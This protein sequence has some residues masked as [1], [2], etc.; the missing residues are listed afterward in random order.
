[1]RQRLERSLVFRRPFDLSGEIVPKEFKTY[2]ELIQLLESRNVIT[3]EN[4]K[5]QLM[6]ESYYAIVNG[7]KDPFLDNK[8]MIAS[9][10][11]IYRKGTKF[12]WIYSLFSFDRDL[13]S[14]TFR[15]LTRAEATMKNA[16]MYAFCSAYPDPNAYLDRSSYVDPKDMLV[17]SS[18]TGNKTLLHQDNL[19]TLMRILN[20]KLSK[21]SKQ[22][23]KHYMETY[24]FVPLWVLQNDLTFGNISNFYQL[25][26]RSIQNHACKLILEAN[27]ETQKRLTA[28]KLLRAFS[29]LVDFRNIC[30]HDERL[31]CA[32]V[33]KSQDIDYSM[34][35]TYLMDVIPEEEFMQFLQ[36]IVD[37]FNKHKDN[38]HV[39]S[40]ESL[41]KGMG[42]KIVKQSE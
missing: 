12:E 13:R 11:D 29:V 4:T 14:I 34:M 15:Y 3:D 5:T 21:K 26:K 32:K 36:E 16:V 22:F 23:T 2:D 19:T 18:Y 28:D 8:A 41:L 35:L 33:G 27:K 25:Q 30:A 7:Y 9:H 17:A 42:F 1:M 38:L 24:G 39:V 37:L 40:M 31:Y 10:D 6:R 20:S